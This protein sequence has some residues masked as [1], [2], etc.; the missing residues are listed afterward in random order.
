[1]AA[2]FK[3]AWG[4]KVWEKGFR[5]TLC[6]NTG[7]DVRESFAGMLKR[8]VE[9]LNPRFHVDVRGVQWST[10]LDQM[11]QHALPVFLMG[12]Q[13]G[14]DTH[15]YALPFMDSQG[16]FPLSQGYSD[17]QADALVARAVRERDPR[18]RAALYRRLED[19]ADDEAWLVPVSDLSNARVERTW[20]KGFVFR[21]AFVDMPYGSDYYD[22][23]KAE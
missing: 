16:L 2:H 3:K 23:Y 17:P 9:S 12:W 4:G 1:A 7:N 10:Y 20:V 13:G 15:D 11:D 8:S 19:R 6:Y 21:P 5:L 14:V 22:L 18:R